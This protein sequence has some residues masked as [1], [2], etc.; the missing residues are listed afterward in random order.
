M[1]SFNL[2]KEIEA[3]ILFSKHVKLRYTY[4]TITMINIVNPTTG[5]IDHS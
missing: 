5:H 3:Q 2:K 4:A 1:I